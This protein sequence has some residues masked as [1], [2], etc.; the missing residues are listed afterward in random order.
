MAR[1]DKLKEE[2]GWL[3]IIFAILIATDISLVAWL[4]QNYGK[5]N[6][7]LLI[8]CAIGTFLVTFAVVWVN[9]VAYRKID[10]LEEL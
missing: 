3:K 2:V 4:V 5:V 9:R 6:L 8:V 10:Q 1:I 7:R